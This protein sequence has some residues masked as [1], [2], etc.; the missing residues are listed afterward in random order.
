MTVLECSFGK[1]SRGPLGVKQYY[2]ICGSTPQYIDYGY[3][4]FLNEMLK[5]CN[6]QKVPPY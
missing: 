5:S 4:I 1:H 2:N 6:I 3:K